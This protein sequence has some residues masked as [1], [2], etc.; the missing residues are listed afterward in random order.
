[1]SSKEITWQNGNQIC[2]TPERLSVYMIDKE[3][4][5]LWET[6]LTDLEF[7]RSFANVYICDGNLMA[8]TVTGVEYVLDPQTGAI[9][10]KVFMK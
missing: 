6:K 1:M 4:R 10:R 3:G 2:I 8:G 9:L 7:E 5:K